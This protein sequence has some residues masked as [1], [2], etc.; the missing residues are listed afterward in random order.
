MKMTTWK[1]AA[2]L[3]TGCALLTGLCACAAQTDSTETA[4]EIAVA[5]DGTISSQQA[6]K[7]TTS[8]T[9][10]T[11][12]AGTGKT[13]T[14]EAGST[15]TGS[16]R[17]SNI[18]STTTKKGQSG[19]TTTGTTAR[20]GATTTAANGGGSGSSGGTQKSTTTTKK[21]TASNKSTTAATTAA[22]EATGE[23]A[24]R[25]ID[26]S[27]AQSGNG[28]TYDGS[29]LSISAAGTY[30]LTGS[31]SGMI[32]INVSSE[33]K[34]KLRM[35]GVSIV[36]SGAPCIQVDNADRVILTVEDGTSNV[37]ECYSTNSDGDAALFSKDD[38]KIK[39]GGALT[40]FCDNEHGISCNKDLEIEDCD[41]TVDAEKTGIISHKSILIRSGNISAS[42]DNCGIRSRDL[43]DIT[44]GN[45]T[46]CGGKKTGA[47]RGGIISDTGNFLIE[48]GTV[49]AVG[50]NQTIP[51]GQNAAWISFP[52]TISKE[53]S[54]GVS[55]DGMLLASTIPNKK[56]SCVLISDGSLYGGGTCDV[57]IADTYYDSFVLED[58]VTQAI[59]DG[60][61][62]ES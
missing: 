20:K 22:T 45:V 38:L 50:M 12:N 3:L 19:T 58:G 17:A 18:S 43:I 27:V 24:V 25:S 6:D 59:L 9:T 31:L 5:S 40:I 53:N 23:D 1:R 29:V 35:N 56:Y 37:L 62:E 10:T 46:A 33:E 8:T 15:T 4:Q 60:I 7:D 57:W 44:G 41:L 42:G 52:Q 16:T 47:D 49:F 11:K 54:V 36:N 21:A 28:Y 13:T 39:G 61:T 30:S 51:S 55:V 14:S 2:A 48:G 32:S 26:F 34:V